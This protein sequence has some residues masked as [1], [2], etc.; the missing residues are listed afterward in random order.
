VALA[1]AWLAVF[2]AASAASAAVSSIAPPAS[3]AAVSKLSS[4]C[5]SSWPA[6]MSRSFSRVCGPVQGLY[7]APAITP[8]SSRAFRPFLLFFFLPWS[9]VVA[10][11]R[12][13]SARRSCSCA[14]LSVAR[15]F[16]EPET[17]FPFESGP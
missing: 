2:S 1:F 9:V 5:R 16:A 8:A 11:A 13:S 17:P 3:E 4:G 14:F 15:T 6:I 12:S 7:S 10:L